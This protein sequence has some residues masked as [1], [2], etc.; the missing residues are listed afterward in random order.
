MAKPPPTGALPQGRKCYV[1]GSLE[2]IKR[3]CPQR[4]ADK[5]TPD[6]GTTKKYPCRRH[7]R[8]VCP[9]TAETCPY[10]H[11]NVT[12]GG[13]AAP[14]AAPATTIDVSSLSTAQQELI[15]AMVMRHGTNAD[16]AAIVV[17]SVFYEPDS[18]VDVAVATVKSVAFEADAAAAEAIVFGAAAAE[19]ASIMT[20]ILDSGARRS[21][22]LTLG[23][24]LQGTAASSGSKRSSP[25]A[26]SRRSCA[27]T[28][29]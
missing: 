12:T 4:G 5:K 14:A 22:Q 10:D 9:H 29:R 6:K 25:T 7:K 27:R 1:C 13:K 20:D 11:G 15:R 28:G 8:G 17:E 26:A 3:D 18:P 23:T 21:S 16:V 24:V 19:P 2:H